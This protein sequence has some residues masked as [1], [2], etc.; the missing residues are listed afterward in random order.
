VSAI[1]VRGLERRF[2]YTAVLD[3][4]DLGVDPGERVAITGENGS[5]KT[6]LLRVL[7]GL[8]KPTSGAVQMLGGAPSDIGV[9]RRVGVIGH[10]TSLYPRMTA[11]ENIRFWGRLYDDDLAT[12][13][14]RDL[15]AKLGL[16][17]D[18]RRPVSSYSQGMRQRVSVARALSTDPKIL[19]ADEPLAALDAT[20]ASTVAA[21]L[22][23]QR[24]LL[25]ATHDI[26]RIST[27]RTLVLRDGRLEPA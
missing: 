16:D 3:G 11:T 26:T 20:S 8:L 21:L 7:A 12:E 14:G 13:R 6:T 27:T 10:Q 22:G 24:T 5:G 17:P 25:I 4:L 9:R 15:I 2:G 18:D 19:I 1:D 23:A